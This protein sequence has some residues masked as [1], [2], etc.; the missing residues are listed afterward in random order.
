M[1]RLL[2]FASTAP[3]A[4]EQLIGDDLASYV[5]LSREHRDGWG[6]AWF[7]HQGE[8]TVAK[9]VEPAHSSELFGKLARTTEADAMVLHLR[10]ASPGLSIAL[11]NTHPFATEAAAFAHNG[12]I[13]PVPE[14][15]VRLDAA[16]RACLRGTTD[17]ERYFQLLL[18]ATERAGAFEAALPP[19]LRSLRQDFRYTALNFVLLTERRLYAVCDYSAEAPAR[20]GNPEYYT[21]GYR[22]AAGSVVVGSA[23]CW[24]DRP[25][26]RTLGNHQALVIDRGGL[27]TS[28]LDLA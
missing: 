21:I 10:R 2:A 28:V 23:G 9:D 22:Q 11:E 19:L 20:R 13:Q 15:E 3:T 16:T 4:P 25:A 7:D 14:L 6:M 12:W 1:C 17:S 18:A 26:S 27:Q 24:G 5:A 8:L